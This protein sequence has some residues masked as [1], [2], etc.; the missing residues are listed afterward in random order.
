MVLP[1][2]EV[3]MPNNVI[4]SLTRAAPGHEEEFESWFDEHLSEVLQVEGVLS[5]RWFALAA[6]QLVGTPPSSH[7]YLAIYEISGDTARIWND[8]AARRANGLNVPKRGIDDEQTR[9]WAF[10]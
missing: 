8:L 7:Q 9:I 3:R 4:I 6:E 1:D 5:A 10:D 2:E